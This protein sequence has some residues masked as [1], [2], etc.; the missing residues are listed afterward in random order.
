[1][2][3][4]KGSKLG[5]YEI[6]A[7]IGVGGMGEVYRARDAKLK[8]DVAI[9]VLP[10]AFAQDAE[11][12]KRFE[13]EAQVLASLNHPHIA[14]IYGLEENALI[15]ELVE[16]PTLAERITEGPLAWE[17]VLAIA[18]QIAEALEYAHENGIIHRDL[19]PANVKLTLDGDVKVLD[20]GLAK[21]LGDDNAASP[22][23]SLSPTLTRATGVGVLLG[24]AGYMAPEQA[25]G[26]PVDKR[27]DVWAFGVVVF[28]LLT[29][30]RLYSGETASE[31]LAL[32]M[33]QEPS[34]ESLPADIPVHF[35]HLLRRCLTK[36]P[37]ER[38]RDIGEARIALGQPDEEKDIVAVLLTPKPLWRQAL[39]W[40]VAG[41]L[42]FALLAVLLAPR[43]PKR[44]TRLSAEI[45]A[46]AALYLEQGPAVVLSPDGSTLAFVAT[47]ADGGRRQ[48]FVRPLD[49]AEATPLSGAE[50]ARN[51]FFSPDGQS[52]GFFA[53]GKL[54]K[55]AV[56]GGGCGH[57]GRRS[58][59]QGR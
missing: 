27:A 25:K 59:R 47:A 38:L 36:D 14:S 8:R 37:K 39:P 55:I 49:R 52:L 11:R 45:G 53:E 7:L 18:Q 40:V 44:V 46:D 42:A 6:L 50:E 48:L 2:S 9:K 4:A 10:Q 12:M 20:Y 24:T 3:L 28:E 5:G 26:K 13:R 21:A 57:A 22:D 43:A 33:T 54:K 34:W 35:R 29:G 1:M 15:L 23:D 58:K 19:K 31:T 41:S 30:K 32:V 16:R 51:P 56:T 17:E